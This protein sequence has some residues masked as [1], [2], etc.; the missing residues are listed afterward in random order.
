VANTKIVSELKENKKQTMDS[1]YTTNKEYSD[2]T[3]LLEV[4]PSLEDGKAM[5]VDGK[6][7]IETKTTININGMISGH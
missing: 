3:T 2:G 4:K 1:I 5:I 6:P 7:K